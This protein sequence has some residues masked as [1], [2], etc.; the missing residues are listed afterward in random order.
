MPSQDDI[1]TRLAIRLD[2]I[3]AKLDRGDMRIMIVGVFEEF[4]MERPKS[5]AAVRQ[6][7]YRERNKSV[8]RRKQKRNVSQSDKHNKS[9]THVNGFTL[10]EW[11]P[12]M[13]WNAWMES[14]AKLKKAPTLFA[15]QMAVTKLEHLKAEGHAP[16]A[17][18]AQSAF[19][20]WAGLF[21]IQEKR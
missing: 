12:E 9:V 18:L 10:P 2:A 6:A 3:D 17:V 1:L 15:K 5:A 7:R 8:T 13:Q 21:P 19:N 4:G 16:A 20:G 14:R 11:V